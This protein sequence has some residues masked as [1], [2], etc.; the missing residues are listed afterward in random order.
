MKK[1][2]LMFLPYL[3]WLMLFILAP[4]LIIICFSFLNED[5]KPTLENF[6]KIKQYFKIVLKSLK[7]TT[8]ATLICLLIAYPVSY[9]ASKIKKPIYKKMFIV[10]VTLPMW[11]NL[12]LRTYSW[13]SILEKNGLLNNLL[14][15]LKFPTLNLINT[16]YAIIV[17][18]VYD[19]LPFMIIPIYSCIF[20]INQSLIEASEDLG[21]NNFKT[22]K[23]IILPLSIPGIMSGV[24]VVFVSCAFCFLIP[25][26]LGGGFNVLV[27]ELIESQFMGTI[28]NP[29]FGSAIA[30]FL[31]LLIGLIVFLIYKLTKTKIKDLAI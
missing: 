5:L 3:I 4:T 19:F 7:F 17:V 6:F 18:M 28:Y 16:P 21:A 9:F 30:T 22:F 25:R 20:K 27:G 24:C 2:Y 29:W 23:L 13:M 26:L 14:A 8:I 10:A 1:S 15:F 31:M 12:L 11:S